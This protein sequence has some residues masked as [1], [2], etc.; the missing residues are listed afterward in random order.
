MAFP[1]EMIGFLAITMLGS[2][3]FM[4]SRIMMGVGA[5][6]VPI[7]VMLLL[8][9]ADYLLTA[10]DIG[11]FLLAVSLCLG[12]LAAVLYGRLVTEP[13]AAV[14]ARR[15]AIM[16]QPDQGEGDGAEAHSMNRASKA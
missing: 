7:S 4:T 5:G 9:P 14:R 12:L 8:V 2:A 1:F 3:W 10:P 13:A 16:R 6:L 15:R 11:L